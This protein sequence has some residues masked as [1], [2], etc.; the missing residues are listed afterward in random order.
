[1]FE[2]WNEDVSNDTTRYA[3]C[4]KACLAL[5]QLDK[6]RSIP[7]QGHKYSYTQLALALNLAKSVTSFHLSSGDL[8]KV[9]SIIINQLIPPEEDESERT[10]L[11]SYVKKKLEFPSNLPVI[12]GISEEDIYQVL[13]EACYGM[14]VLY[15]DPIANHPVCAV[16]LPVKDVHRLHKVRGR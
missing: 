16:R 6:L 7:G 10:H 9:L 3:G 12:E 1:M 8:R 4:F 14:D 11:P 2:V 13:F 15:R 5:A